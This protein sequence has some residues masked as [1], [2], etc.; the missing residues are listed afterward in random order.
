MRP[1]Q[2]LLSVIIG[3][4]S[5]GN[6]FNFGLDWIQTLES[7]GNNSLVGGVLKTQ[8]TAFADLGEL[9]NAADFLPAL[10]GLTVYGQIGSTSMSSSTRWNRPIAS[11]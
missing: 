3:E 6:E 5:L 2:I 9:G 4:F 11:T 7:V 10:D 8:G 1:E